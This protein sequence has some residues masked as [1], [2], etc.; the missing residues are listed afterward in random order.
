MGD[1][2]AAIGEACDVVVVEPDAVRAGE[3]G[4]EKTERIEMHGQRPAIAPQARHG[5]HA[6][7][8]EMHVKRGA[9]LG[10]E[11]AAAGD[12]RV[13]AMKRD[14]RRQRDARAIR[15][16]GPAL[17]DVP[18]GGERRRGR[19]GAKALDLAREAGR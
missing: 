1:S 3:V 12:E 17:D 10:R 16:A 2:A 7:F 4:A 19:R 13:A 14:G 5:L 8:G 9:E 18:Q 15:I 11:I 6:R